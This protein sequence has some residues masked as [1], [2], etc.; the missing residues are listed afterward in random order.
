VI[1]IAIAH[2]LGVHPLFQRIEISPA[3]VSV[4][5]VQPYGPL[6]LLVNGGCAG[7]LLA[8]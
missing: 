7:R 4:V 3:S 8:D 5:D 6:V 2:F 1:K